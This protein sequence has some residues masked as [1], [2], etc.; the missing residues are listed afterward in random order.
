MNITDLSDLV[1][2]VAKSV[3]WQMSGGY[4]RIVSMAAVDKCL[5]WGHLSGH[6]CWLFTGKHGYT[7][8]V[9]LL[10]NLLCCKK[11]ISSHL[12]GPSPCQPVAGMSLCDPPCALL[13]GS[14]NW[15]RHHCGFSPCAF[16]QSDVTQSPGMSKR[17]SWISFQIVSVALVSR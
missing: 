16:C 11:M 10:Q 7:D 5:A 15:Q 17:A 4:R 9:A 3:D 2:D 12:F 1:S 14:T 13:R 8:E 6:I